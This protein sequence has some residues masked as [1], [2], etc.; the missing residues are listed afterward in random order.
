MLPQETVTGL[1]VTPQGIV[2]ENHPPALSEK[3]PFSPALSN[4]HPKE[5]VAELAVPSLEPGHWERLH[6]ELA[7][8]DL[9]H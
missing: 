2:E 8:Q 3:L 6:H 7:L 5:T 4:K 1:V 9:G